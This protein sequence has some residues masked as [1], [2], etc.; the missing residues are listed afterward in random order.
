MAASGAPINRSKPRRTAKDIEDE[1]PSSESSSNNMHSNLSTQAEI[2]A[3]IRQRKG[4]GDTEGDSSESNESYTMG[5][6]P[7]ISSP[8]LGGSPSRLAFNNYI[9]CIS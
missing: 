9:Y 6:R 1:S 7:P 4:K 8:I 2:E 5:G 3:R